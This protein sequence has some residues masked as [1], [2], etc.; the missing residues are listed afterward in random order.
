MCAHVGRTMPE[1]AAA[2]TV[3]QMQMV[4]QM[5]QIVIAWTLKG[6]GA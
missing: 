5:S 3:T 4:Q 2:A 6:I 1:A